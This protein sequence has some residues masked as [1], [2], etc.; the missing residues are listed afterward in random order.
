M[1]WLPGTAAITGP[2]WIRLHS[3]RSC[4]PPCCGDRIQAGHAF[5]TR[6]GD[7]KACG[8]TCRDRSNVLNIRGEIYRLRE[9]RQAVLFPS[10]HHQNAAPEEAG[11]NHNHTD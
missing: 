8:P 4:A 2:A 1:I 9:K 11:N 6:A 3:R 10:Q 5:D 7:L